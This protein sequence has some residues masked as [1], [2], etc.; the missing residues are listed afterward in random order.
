MKKKIIKGITCAVLFAIIFSIIKTEVNAITILETAKQYLLDSGFTEE[1]LNT[2]GDS[3]ILELYETYKDE[4]IVCSS[5]ILTENMEP[6]DPNANAPMA[7]INPSELT[8]TIT[9]VARIINYSSTF[10]VGEVDYLDVVVSYNWT[11]YK[12]IIKAKD[13]IVL[14]FNGNVFSCVEYGYCTSKTYY[15]TNA[16][17]EVLYWSATDR[18]YATPAPS[19]VGWEFP[20]A[21]ITGVHHYGNGKVT[22]SPTH[23]M[24]LYDDGTLN[25]VETSLHAY[26][27]HS[28]LDDLEP[29]LAVNFGMLGFSMNFINN[30]NT[31]SK[32]KIFYYTE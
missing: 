4:R 30:S 17:N 25:N 11:P 13:A 10:D 20:V 23:Q 31:M 3:F 1:V 12:P 9:T 7:E 32:N 28:T 29:S 16:G 22:L 21:P 26:Y 27:Y 5:E 6:T 19:G 2:Y 8:L 14:N 15:R 18:P 24:F